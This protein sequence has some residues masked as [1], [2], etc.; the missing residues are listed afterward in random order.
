MKPRWSGGGNKPPTAFFLFSS[1]SFAHSYF[2]SN[3]KLT[4]ALLLAGLTTSGAQFHI[5]R[6]RF[7]EAC[8]TDARDAL[9]YLRQH[10]YPAVDHANAGQ[11]REFHGSAIKEQLKWWESKADRNEHTL[12]DQISIYTIAQTGSRT[13]RTSIIMGRIFSAINTR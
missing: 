8:A 5:R 2:T 3:M 12:C 9:L 10:V 1:P 4:S 11:V 13:M 6:Q 7:C